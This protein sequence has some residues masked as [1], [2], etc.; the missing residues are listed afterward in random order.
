MKVSKVFKVL[1]DF[2][3]FRDFKDIRVFKVVG[4]FKLAEGLVGVGKVAGP[5]RHPVAGLGEGA[6]HEPVPLGA[7]A[8][9]RQVVERIDDPDGHLAGQ[10]TSLRR[11]C[12][13]RRDR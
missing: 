6:G 7:V 11:T 4:A 9:R 5:V 12:P 2:K 8:L 13:C 10:F 3:V 1:K